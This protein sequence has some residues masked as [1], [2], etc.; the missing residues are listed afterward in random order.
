MGLLVLGGFT[1]EP[2]SQPRY[3]PPPTRLFTGYDLSG[4]RKPTGDWLTANA[5]TTNAVDPKRFSVQ[6]GYGI[7][8]NGTNGQTVN[9]ISELE[10][11]DCEV[12]IEFMVPLGSNSGIYF[13]GRYEIQILDS[14]LAHE[15]KPSDCGG[16]YERWRDNRGFDGHAP[17]INASQPPGAWQT[18]DVIFQAPRFDAHGRKRENAR[19]IRVLH[20]G[21]LIHENISLSGPTR[22]AWRENDEAARGPLMLQGDHGPVAFRNFSIRSR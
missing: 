11:G 16:I 14:Y 13:Q 18:F 15:P 22:A 8:V 2:V 19:F 7:L 17:R 10:H 4:W 21:A 6:G 5:V 9:L 3:A 12:H 1:K 20:N